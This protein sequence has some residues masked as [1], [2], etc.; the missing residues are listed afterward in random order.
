M[1][2]N[3]FSYFN[4]RNAGDQ[5]VVRLL[6]KKCDSI[7]IAATHWV[8]VGGKR[9]CVKCVGEG[10]PLC[11]RKIDLNERIYLHLWDYTDNKEKVWVRTGTIM[12][13]LENIEKDWGDLSEVVVRIMRETDNFPTYQVTPLP[14]KNYG[15]VDKSLVDKK[16]AYRCFLT[17]S[18]EEIESFLTTG[19]MPEHKSNY[20]PKEQYMAQRAK[21]NTPATPKP[22][23]PAP[24][25]AP[26]PTPFSESP[27]AQPVWAYNSVQPTQAPV[28]GGYVAQTPT[29][30]TFPTQ[31]TAPW[32]SDD[33]FSSP[34]FRI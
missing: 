12:P 29:P 19:V 31:Q 17:R 28:N 23:T 34:I 15:E 10:C 24:Q 18:A 13:Q 9:K 11:A 14:P 8:D 25:P 1:A 5:A 4:L 22:A 2:D 20:V 26:A 6:H 21:A 3:Q 27:V 16:I 7:E 33:P 32:E 30:T